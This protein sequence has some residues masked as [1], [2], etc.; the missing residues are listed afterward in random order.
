M[1]TSNFQP[2]RLFDPGCLTKS[3][4]FWTNSADSYLS[5]EANLSGSTVC[6]GMTYLVQQNKV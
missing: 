1:P 6:K 2:I 3:H 5:E 4:T